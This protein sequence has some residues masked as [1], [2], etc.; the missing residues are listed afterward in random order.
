M[1]NKIG[2]YGGTFDPPHVGHMISARQAIDQLKLKTLFI[3]PCKRSEFKEPVIDGDRRY[4]MVNRMGVKGAVGDPADLNREGAYTMTIDTINHLYEREKL[5]DNKAELWMILGSD[6][7]LSLPTWEDPDIIRKLVKIAVIPRHHDLTD[8][9]TKLGEPDLVLNMPVMDGI[10]STKIRQ[11]IRDGLDITYLVSPDV[12]EYI[13][14][15]KL[16][17]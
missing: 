7:W 15:R 4:N 6:S 2:L 3:T 12:Q 10:S 9:T 14:T 11:M 13:K 17:I 16:Y 5:D 1:I 8:Y